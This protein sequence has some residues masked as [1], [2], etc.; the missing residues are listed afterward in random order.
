[1]WSS[2]F[3]I[4]IVLSPFFVCFLLL[5]LLFSQVKVGLFDRGYRAPLL[6]ERRSGRAFECNNVSIRVPRRLRVTS[7]TFRDYAQRCVRL[8]CKFYVSC[9]ILLLASR[10]QISKCAVRHTCITYFLEFDT[11]AL[12]E[13]PLGEGRGKFHEAEGLDVFSQRYI[14][15]CFE[16]AFASTSTPYAIVCKETTFSRR[17]YIS[18]SPIA[19]L[20]S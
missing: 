11:R 7:R 14:G 4:N 1:M 12:S 3:L 20:L 8:P 18:S 2:T 13:F 10:S 16:M 9:L 17:R 5:A 15:T 19:H 6:L